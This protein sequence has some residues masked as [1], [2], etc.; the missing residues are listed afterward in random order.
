MSLTLP[1][2]YSNSS[3]LGNIQENWIVQLGYDDEG[4]ND[5]TGIALSDTTV[6]GVFYHGAITNVPSIRSSIDLATSTA[7]TGN[8]SLSVINFQFKGDDFSA[9]LFLGTRKYIN[10]NVKIYSQLNGDTTLA[11]CLQIYQGR[12]IDISHDD[13]SISLQLTEQ[14][15]WDFI[16]I[17]LP[18]S[19]TTSN[20]IPIPVSYGAFTKNSATTFASPLFVSALTAKT[21]RPVQFNK[22]NDEQSLYVDGVPSGSN[23]ELAH[24]EK[25]VDVFVPFE[26][27]VAG[28]SSTDG[29]DHAKIEPLQIRAFKQRADTYEA[30]TNATVTVANIGDS[31]NTDDTD[32]ATFSVNRVNTNDTDTVIYDFK[33]VNPSGM[34][35]SYFVRAKESDGDNVS[36]AEAISASESG[37]DVSNA[38]NLTSYDVIRIDNEEMNITSISSNTLTVQRGFNGTSAVAHDNASAVLVDNT[39][40]VVGIKYGIT[41]ATISGDLS[42]VKLFISTDGNYYTVTRTSTLSTSTRSVNLSNGTTNIRIKITFTSDDSSTAGSLNATF[43]LYDIFFRTQRISEEPEDI[44]F[45]GNDGLT[46]S[47]TGSSNAI[48]Y[49][50]E[51]HRDM[52]I[53]FAGYTTTAPGNWSALNTDRAIA[54]WKIRWWELEPTD[55]KKALEKLQYEFGFI[56]KFR[57]DGTGS[58]IHILQTSELSAVQTFKKDDINNL[59]IT[60]SSLSGLLTKMEINYEKHPAENRYFSSVTSSNSTART[61]YNIQAKENIKEVNLDMNVGTPNASGQ[62]DGN[63]DFYSY[64][65]N[66]FGDIKKIISCDI[67]NSAKGYSLETG[68]IVQFSNTAGEMPVDPFGDN[69]ADYYMITDLNRSPGN[70][71]ITAREVG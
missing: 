19:K 56:F 70:V 3:K 15:P 45:T 34:K 53:R 50:H 66:I 1:T 11:N 20:N 58:Y 61:N 54:T 28:T 46:E 62:T 49:G 38:S 26:N 22:T 52:L 57:A 68:D 25:G 47:W 60:N 7:K 21:Y 27:G 65:D 14:R 55:L 8:I 39:I 2:A 4:A 6:G 48:Q 24:Y 23:S 40:N 16:S 71:S 63:A 13:S 17:P 30:I 29:A 18:D 9:E 44:V 43:S 32:A 67:V 35:S 5:W 10:R 51:A 59:K 33:V 41:I 36:A 31:I 37:I 42:N 12:L 69:W 64:Y